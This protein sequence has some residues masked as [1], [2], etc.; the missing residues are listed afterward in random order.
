L[1]SETV[2]ARIPCTAPLLAALAIIAAPAARGA[3]PVAA[4]VAEI[5]AKHDRA[6]IRELSEYLTAHPKAD[7]RDQAYA[8]LF[9]KAI[10]H[11]WFAEV[12]DLGRQYLKT[13]PEGPVKALAQIVQT[14]ARAQ[15]GRYDDAL[16]RFRELVKG[17]DPNEQE[18]F[19]TSFSDSFAAQAITSGEYSIA[20]Q[21][22]ATLLDRFGE[23]PSLRQ[24]IQ[25]DLKRL[26]QVGRTAPSFNA[27]DIQGR[28]IRSDALRGKYVLL[29]FW[30]TWC[31]PC[32]AE[33]PRL[34]AA[35]RSYH[36]AGLEIIGVSLD[37]S[38]EAVVDFV[39][40]RK[41]PWPQVHNSGASSDLVQ[42]FGVSSI[43]ATYL[44]DPQGTV[45]R[46][47]LRGKALDDTLARLI[48][49]T[50]A[51]TGAR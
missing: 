38:K 42:A 35:Y 8:S 27:E 9:N 34:Q 28:A 18:E 15:A 39:K 26:D 47:D 19:A 30:A 14:M 13:D 7:D 37:E 31:G 41:V 50:A 25:G 16:A 3:E 36:E 4:S 2:K 1:R 6:L 17:L 44:I 29:D 48:K 10:E 46:L 32:I 43:P 5:Q 20:R 21:A 40:A 22:Y 24:K 33:L 51:T 11:D 45:I 49:G 23:S 12:E